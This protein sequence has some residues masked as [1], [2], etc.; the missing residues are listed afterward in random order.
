MNKIPLLLLSAAALLASSDFAGAAAS[1]SAGDYKFA[2]V[3][4]EVPAALSSAFAVDDPISG[5]MSLS[6]SMKVPIATY[7]LAYYDISDFHANFGGD[8]QLDS[9]FGVFT[10]IN[11]DLGSDMVK[12]EVSSSAGMTGPTVAGHSPEY[13]SSNLFID[14]GVLTS[15]DL[16]SQFILSNTF[17]DVS[18]L[19][20]DVNDALSVRFRFTDISLVPE[21]T[22]AGLAVMTL[23]AALLKASSTTTGGRGR[24]P[25]TRVAPVA[26]FGYRGGEAARGRPSP[27]Q[28]SLTAH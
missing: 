21:P 11:F 28:R 13:F 15:T 8:Y 9:P 20:Y 4:T 1:L 16:R 24:R 7:E 27:T 6:L 3:V 18:G 2:G 19:R 17:L 14:D 25:R 22:A 10:I 26:V 23:I 5:S 12:V